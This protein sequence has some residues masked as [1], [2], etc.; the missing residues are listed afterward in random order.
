MVKFFS[1]ENH[2]LNHYEYE[3]VV[4]LGQNLADTLLALNLC[5]F[6]LSASYDRFRL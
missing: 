5:V 3:A 6:V 2:S 4:V 1:S